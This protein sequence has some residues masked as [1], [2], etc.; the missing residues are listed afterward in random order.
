M[1]TEKNIF[2]KAL[3]HSMGKQDKPGYDPPERENTL[4]LDYK[5]FLE[6]TKTGKPS[7]DAYIESLAQEMQAYDSTDPYKK[8][9]LRSI[10][11]KA[12][13]FLRRHADISYEDFLRQANPDEFT[14]NDYGNLPQRKNLRRRLFEHRARLYLSALDDCEKR[15][16][17]L[18]ELLSGIEEA[19]IPYLK[20]EKDEPTFK[21]I[22]RVLGRKG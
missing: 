7:F 16:Y 1:R 8:D 15:G 4:S 21:E 18:N 19:T 10:T 17:R 20:K 22:L 11:D 9:A 13:S 14:E 5:D 3:H 6:R 2:G 12:D